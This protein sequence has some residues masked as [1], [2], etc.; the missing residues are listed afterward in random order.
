MMGLVMW[1]V[2]IVFAGIECV[3]FQGTK[4]NYDS[5]ISDQE[6]MKYIAAYKKR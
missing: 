4:N 3:F 6:Q 2:L 5:N 1:I